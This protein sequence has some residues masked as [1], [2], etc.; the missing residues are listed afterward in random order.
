MRI[1]LLRWWEANET[2][3]SYGV[4]SIPL[5]ICFDGENIWVANNGSANVT[6]VRVSDGTVLGT[7]SVGASPR[8]I[9]FDGANVWVTN[10]ASTVGKH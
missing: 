5:G 3:I 4:G 10:G 9:C 1:A 6:K 8:G 2:G 7:Y